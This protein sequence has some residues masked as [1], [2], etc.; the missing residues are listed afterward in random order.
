MPLKFHSVVEIESQ[1][2]QFILSVQ[3]AVSTGLDACFH[4]SN[5]KM[6]HAK[7]KSPAGT[8]PSATI[9]RRKSRVAR[10]FRMPQHGVDRGRG[11]DVTGLNERSIPGELRD[12]DWIADATGHP[13]EA[14]GPALPPLLPACRSMSGPGEGTQPLF[15]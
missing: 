5:E 14:K 4:M 9:R 11:G 3:T 1:G 10:E 15:A 8:S 2:R 7:L 13:S 6:I 12:G